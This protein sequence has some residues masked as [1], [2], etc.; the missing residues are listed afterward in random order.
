M[1]KKSSKDSQKYTVDD[2]AFDAVC[3]ILK[4][5]LGILDPKEL[6]AAENDAYITAFEKAVELFESDQQF[7]TDDICRLNKLFLGNIYD[8][9]GTFR[10]VDLISDDIR[11]C[12]A[13]YI[14]KEMERIEKIL[15]ALTPFHPGLTEAEIIQRLAEIFGEL[16]VIHPFREGNG[17]TA[18]LLC[19]LLLLQANYQPL[20]VASFKTKGFLQIYH[21]AIRDVWTSADFAKLK[22]FFDQLLEKL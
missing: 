10:T 21:A 1:K 16:I 4:N 13:Q 5:K 6:E 11:W 9:A 7:T 18:G 20:D 14:P 22:R 3:N 15:A 19:N 12:H 8:W 2:S 17:R